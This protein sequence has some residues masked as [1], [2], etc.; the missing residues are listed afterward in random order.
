MGL[1]ICFIGRSNVG[2][3]SLLN[4]IFNQKIVKTS[5]TPGRT[6]LINYFKHDNK[7]FVDLP[8]YGY[9][10]VSK[11]KKQAM[12]KMVQNYFIERKNLLHTFLLIDVKIGITSLDKLAISFF[13]SNNVPFTIIGTKVDKATQKEKYKTKESIK[14]VTNIFFITST[15]NNQNINKLKEYI[16]KLFI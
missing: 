13:K 1:E 14:D 6:Q 5:K 3:S 2:K 9:A 11:I 12:N 10:R 16:N 4:N 8:G 7:I 15:K